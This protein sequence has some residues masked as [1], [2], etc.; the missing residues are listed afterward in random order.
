MIRRCQSCSDRISRLGAPYAARW[1]KQKN[2][3]S[4]VSL[5]S[6]KRANKT[7]IYYSFLTSNSPKILF[8]SVP[9]TYLVQ[10]SQKKHLPNVSSLSPQDS[11]NSR[12]QNACLSASLRDQKP[13]WVRAW[14]YHPNIK[15]NLPSAILPQSQ[16]IPQFSLQHPAIHGGFPM[17]SRLRPTGKYCFLHCFLLLLERV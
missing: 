16:S 10:E 2:L 5:N 14:H 4:A 13:E 6:L 9:K 8:F 11:I 1:Q 3:L 12:C 17:I 15:L 7:F